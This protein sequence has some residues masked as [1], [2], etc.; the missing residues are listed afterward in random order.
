MFQSFFAY[1]HHKHYSQTL[2]TQ[3]YHVSLESTAFL[4][5]Y[6]KIKMSQKQYLFTFS[7]L[8]MYSVPVHTDGIPWQ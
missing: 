5:H 4:A 1:V 7:L 2:Y 3:I 6:I 8:N